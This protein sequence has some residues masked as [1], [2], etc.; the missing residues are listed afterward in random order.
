MTN[1]TGKIGKL[2]ENLQMV[3]MNLKCY[4]KDQKLH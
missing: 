3:Q 4:K 1:F 2:A